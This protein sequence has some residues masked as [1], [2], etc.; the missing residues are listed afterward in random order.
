MP[1]EKNAR[2]VNKDED[3]ERKRVR[4]S[5]ADP[6]RKSFLQNLDSDL[7]NKS[8]ENAYEIK[9]NSS[10]PIG[11]SLRHVDSFVDIL[12]GIR[13]AGESS[14]SNSHS[15][16]LNSPRRQITDSPNSSF[17]S[18]TRI[19]N[20]SPRIPL[21]VKESQAEISQD[22]ESIKF[23]NIQL[24]TPFTFNGLNISNQSM[25]LLPRKPELQKCDNLPENLYPND[26][27]TGNSLEGLQKF[28]L[29]SKN[30]IQDISQIQSAL[31]VGSATIDR[32]IL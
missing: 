15:F 28:S 1:E 24:Q 7:A 10:T 2:E 4:V 14:S 32:E 6:R 9:S 18:F 27:R 29:L 19:Q 26:M 13:E 12:L 30:L 8:Y 21:N 25:T 17:L 3:R 11:K 5:L 31:H 23:P 16:P 22:T 20:I